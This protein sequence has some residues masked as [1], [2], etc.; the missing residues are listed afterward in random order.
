MS[1][2]LFAKHGNA[3]RQHPS[4]FFASLEYTC[5]RTFRS[6]SDHQPCVVSIPSLN[7]NTKHN[8]RTTTVTVHSDNFVEKIKNEISRINIMGLLNEQDDPNVNFHRFENAVLT[9]I[10]KHTY[11]KRVKFNKYK[12]KKMPWIT[13][14]ILKSIKF[15]DRLYARFRTS[16]PGSQ[17]SATL[18][19]NLSTYNKILKKLIRAAKIMY[20][21]CSFER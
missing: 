18:K 9:A 2:T 6:L 17:L 19:I 10:K 20:Y 12:H 13:Q 11:V 5:R 1:N 4:Q 3:N 7:Q 15:R 14:G 21:N 8:D 16:T